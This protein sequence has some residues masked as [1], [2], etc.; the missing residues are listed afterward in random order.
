M[1]SDRIRNPEEFQIRECISD[2][3]RFRYP[4][5]TVTA[6]EQNCPLCG[7]PDLISG[8]SFAGRIPMPAAKI[9]A[10]ETP[11]IEVLLDNLRSSYNVGSIFR[12]CDGAGIRQIHLCGITSTPAQAK[13]RKTALSAH[14][15]VSWTYHR[16]ALITVQDFQKQGYRVWS[17]ENSVLCESVFGVVCDN[18]SEPIL[19]VVGNELSGVDPDI[20]T[21][22][23]KVICVPMAGI[24]SS[25][26]VVVAFGIA[27][28]R[29]RFAV[30]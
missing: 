26:N 4:V 3:C 25:L 9:E 8:K 13:V 2:E 7:A 27:A 12:T 23:E 18:L 17:L 22:S 29:L 16:N 19:L 1:G 6:E 15:A 28:Y 24:K 5:S 14:A 30:K 21:L 10:G 20:L 11:F